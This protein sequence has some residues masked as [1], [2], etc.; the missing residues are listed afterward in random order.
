[1]QRRSFQQVM[2]WFATLAGADQARNL[3]RQRLD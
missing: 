3:L 1:L 2:G